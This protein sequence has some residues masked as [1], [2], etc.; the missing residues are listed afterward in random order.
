MDKNKITN[1]NQEVDDL[2]KKGKEALNELMKFNQDKINEIVHAMVIAGVDQHMVLAKA[3]VDET[4]RGIWED[5]CIK[6]LY[7]TET[8]W[9]SI[10]YAKTCG[11]IDEILKLA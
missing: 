10:K 8:I 9:H 7:S 11:V 1:V 4:K 3:A 6:N 2:V 5:K